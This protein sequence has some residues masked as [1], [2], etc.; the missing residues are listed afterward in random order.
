MKETI[1]TIITITIG[2]LILITIFTCISIGIELGMKLSDKI[3]EK[4]DEI[5]EKK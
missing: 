1:I 4:I 2:P 5:F 3:Q